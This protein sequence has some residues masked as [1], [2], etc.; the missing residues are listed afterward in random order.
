M[1]ALSTN[2]SARR[3]RGSVPIDANRLLICKDRHPPSWREHVA[4]FSKGFPL[5]IQRRHASKP[6]LGSQR[7]SD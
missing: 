3:L 1:H 4:P 7:V 2:W 5:K 6:G